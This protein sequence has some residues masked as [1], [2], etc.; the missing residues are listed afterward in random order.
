MKHFEKLENFVKSNK[1]W[2]EILKPNMKSIYPV[3]GRNWVVLMYN[4]MDMPKDKEIFD[5]M[6]QC[7]GTVIDKTTGEIICA[8]FTKFWNYKDE[9]VAA[10]IDWPSAWVSHKRDGWIF[11]AFKWH[12]NV[13]WMSNG[14]VITENEKG[15]PVDYVPGLPRLNNM[16]DVLMR[17]LKN[18]MSSAF[19][20]DGF[21]FSN[22]EW[23]KRMPEGS[24]AMFELESP[25]NR[26]HT[27]LVKDAKLWL[28]GFR[29]PSGDEI[30][31]TEAKE[32]FNFPFETPKMYDF[33][34]AKEMLDVLAGWNVKD[35]GEGVVVCDKYFNRVKVKIDDYIRVKFESRGEDFGDNRLFKY[36]CM[37]E[38][39]DLC[40]ADPKV[41]A[42]VEEISHNVQLYKKW[43]EEK[44]KYVNTV[45]ATK[46]ADKK[47]FFTSVDDDFPEDASLF[48]QLYNK[49]AENLFKNFIEKGKVSKTLYRDTL[50]LMGMEMTD[51]TEE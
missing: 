33:K 11:K 3:E 28:I 38:V 14:R 4:L 42:R 24:T 30:T 26:I 31:F 46:Y 49:N 12:G 35:N 39:D 50:H 15:A 45:I 5:I 2:E 37:N 32:R 44:V 51:G 6:C 9:G 34:S 36:Y 48:K 43:L 25:W 41:K 47:E 19:F 13:Y 16:S 10:D 21:L 29:M 17:A 7:R 18:D 27:D 40:A 1:N 8:P 22:C 20:S 23:A